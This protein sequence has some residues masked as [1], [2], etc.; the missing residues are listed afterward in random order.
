MEVWEYYSD[1]TKNSMTKH[2]ELFSNF[3]LN[4]SLISTINYWY[5]KSGDISNDTLIKRLE[6]WNNIVKCAQVDFNPEIMQ[7]QN[8]LETQLSTYPSKNVT[9]DE[10]EES[11]L[12]LITLRN[13]IAKQL[14]YGNYA[15]MVLQNTGIDTTWFEKL[16]MTIDT[17]SAEKYEIF[18]QNHFPK[19]SK[20]EYGDIIDYI[21]QA[22][23]INDDPVIEDSKKEKLIHE[24]L[25]NIGIEV[26]DLPIQ[27]EITDLPPGIGG[28]GNGIDIPNDFRAVATKELSYYYLLHEIGHGINWTNVSINYPILKGYEWCTGN[29]NDAYSESMAE[30]IAKFSQNTESLKKVG[31]SERYIDSIQ[32]HRKEINPVYLR[33]GLINTLFEVELYKN[34]DKDPAIIKSE[35]YAKYLNINKDFSKRPNLIRL[36]Y[37]SYPV[38]EQNY[39]IA[40]IISWQIHEYLENEFGEDYVINPKVGDFLKENLWK[41]GELYSSQYKIKKATGKEL[42][43][44][45][46]LKYLLE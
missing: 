15:Y 21:I 13:D 33:L 31:F 44:P 36:S 9:D 8:L 14:G 1:S 32:S 22:Y 42:D 40:D 25:S 38:Y 6:L 18:I 28:F 35:L 7:L 39:L 45:G 23:M 4:D 20:I 27:F 16:I 5:T 12:K 24:T 41:N 34:P 26:S 17:G 3:L 37:V 46:Y 43:L 30:V 2:K 11:V 19:N 29:S 10:I